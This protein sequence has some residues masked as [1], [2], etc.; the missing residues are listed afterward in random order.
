MPSAANATP[1]SAQSSGWAVTGTG[2]VSSSHGRR[3]GDVV[4][5]VNLGDSHGRKRGELATVGDT[6]SFG[7]ING[8]EC[9]EEMCCASVCSRRCVKIGRSVNSGDGRGSGRAATW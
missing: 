1:H 5:V 4:G 8:D 7:R 6:G 9:V 2:P 3:R